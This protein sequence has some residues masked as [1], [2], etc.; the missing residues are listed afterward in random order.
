MYACRFNLNK[1][2]EILMYHEFESMNKNKDKYEQTIT[3]HQN[4]KDAHI[5]FQNKLGQSAILI[6]T[7]YNSLECMKM[8][9]KCPQINPNLQEYKVKQGNTIINASVLYF[10]SNSHL[11]LTELHF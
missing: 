3:N 7:H 1:S 8:L 11:S 4:I 10:C 9:L 6:A 5:N 2:L